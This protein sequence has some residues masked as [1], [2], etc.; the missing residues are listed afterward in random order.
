M[1]LLHT[2][3]STSN[4]LL[5]CQLKTK[6]IH[7][8]KH[9]THTRKGNYQDKRA[10]LIFSSQMYN[11]KQKLTLLLEP[12]SFIH[13]ISL[14]HFLRACL[15]VVGIVS[16]QKYFYNSCT[17]IFDYQ[18]HIPQSSWLCRPKSYDGNYYND[19]LTNFLAVCCVTLVLQ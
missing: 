9:K 16:P 12:S 11:C 13:I 5:L 4:I 6:W 3:V 10:L 14:P 19:T 2:F 18:P 8:R 7:K 17:K 15:I 1:L